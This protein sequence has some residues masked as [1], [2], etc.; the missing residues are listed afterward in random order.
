MRFRFNRIKVLSLRM[1][2]DLRSI[3]IIVAFFPTLPGDY[4]KKACKMLG[5]SGRVECG[6][7]ENI[8]DYVD[9]NKHFNDNKYVKFSRI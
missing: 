5:P 1:I 7:L 8:Y 2:S 4:L 6:L 3:V 9:D